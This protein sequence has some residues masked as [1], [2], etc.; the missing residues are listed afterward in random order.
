VREL[1][2]DLSR[3]EDVA[4]G[5]ETHRAIAALHRGN[6]D[7]EEEEDDDGETSS[8][9]SKIAEIRP[10]QHSSLL[11]QEAFHHITEFA[12]SFQRSSRGTSASSTGGGSRGTPPLLRAHDALSS[13]VD[14]SAI[15]RS[16]APSVS[17]SEDDAA[18]RHEGHDVTRSQV[19]TSQAISRPAG[20]PPAPS[21]I[22]P[23]AEPS[24]FPGGTQS[25]QEVLSLEQA[26]I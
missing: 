12:S 18:S 6:N 11:S 8:E 25:S 5:V 3:G 19:V 14:P 17:S 2:M 20:Q 13:T 21:G 24:A 15:P 26:R 16:S 10:L 9:C 23:P 7:E 4:S 1:E 22:S